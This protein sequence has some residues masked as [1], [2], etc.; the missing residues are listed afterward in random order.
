MPLRANRMSA[1][2]DLLVVACLTALVFALAVRFELSEL[3]LV[4][5]RR[6]EHVQLDE[7]VLTFLVLSLALTWFAWRRYR[8]ARAE[9]ERRRATEAQLSQLLLEHRQLAQQHLQVQEMERKVLAREL[10]DELGQY[11]NAIKIDAV[12]IHCK[13]PGTDSP[14]ARGAAAI[15]EHVDHVY[16]VVRDLIRRLRPIGLDELGLEAALEQYVDDWKRRL[17]SIRFHLS[18]EGDLDTVNEPVA[19]AV[20]RLLQEGMTN[21]SRHAQAGRVDIHVQRIES[22]AAGSRMLFSMA[23][24]GRGTDLSAMRPGLGLIGMRERIEALGGDLQVSAEAGRGFAIRADIPAA[25]TQES[26]AA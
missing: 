24:D 19:L 25:A 3:V 26:E 10:H 16:A 6:F 2:R 13:A 8:E 1:R 17:P 23:D 22:S 11:L 15:I 5:T 9:L 4:I 12:S 21:V 18:L 20:Y 7:L 14:V